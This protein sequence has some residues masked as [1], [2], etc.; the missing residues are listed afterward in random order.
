[1][2]IV[3]LMENMVRVLVLTAPICNISLYRTV[4]SGVIEFRLVCFNPYFHI[5]D[6]HHFFSSDLISLDLLPPVHP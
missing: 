1:M 6:G 2:G 4:E 3:G 5:E